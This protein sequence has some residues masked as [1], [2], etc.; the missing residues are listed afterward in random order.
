MLAELAV[1]KKVRGD[2]GDGATPGA[3]PEECLAALQEPGCEG[4]G[5]VGVVRDPLGEFHRLEEV[6]IRPAP[7]VRPFHVKGFGDGPAA[8]NH[9]LSLDAGA[10]AAVAGAV[11]G[12]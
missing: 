11:E 10:A 4:A 2:G 7:G 8:E 1:A 5:L 6:I 12:E 3:L 9:D